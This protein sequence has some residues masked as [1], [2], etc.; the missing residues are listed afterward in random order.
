MTKATQA[1]QK[2]GFVKTIYSGWP[3]ASRA[4]SNFMASDYVPCESPD[5]EA[6]WSMV[7]LRLFTPPAQLG[8]VS[9]ESIGPL[10]QTNAGQEGN[11]GLIISRSGL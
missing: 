9:E 4:F 7:L 1:C 11:T 6:A 3:V 2:L 8:E 5:P 10:A